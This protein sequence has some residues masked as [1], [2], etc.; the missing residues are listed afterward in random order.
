MH[1]DLDVSPPSFDAFEAEIVTIQKELWINAIS[2]SEEL[3]SCDPQMTFSY[4]CR[5]AFQDVSLL[6][7][8]MHHFT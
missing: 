4:A 3:Q 5:H 7:L 2:A 1:A 8:S 6:L